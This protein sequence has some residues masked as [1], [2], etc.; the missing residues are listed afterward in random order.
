MAATATQTMTPP[1][2]RRFL[3]R[4]P[5]PGWLALAAAILVVSGCGLTFWATVWLPH[6]REQ[7]IIDKIYALKGRV[8]FEFI[9]PEW[10]RSLAGDERIDGLTMLN[11]AIAVGLNGTAVSDADLSKLELEKLTKLGG[12]GLSSTRIGD[13][14]LG[15]L[16]GLK[17]L[18]VLNIDRTRRNT[19]D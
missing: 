12:L 6:R 8:E 5:R 2:P 4:L 11:R 3:I 10:V 19:S 1:E 13:A 9:G 7:P 17:G 16:S 18:A 15:H 14:G